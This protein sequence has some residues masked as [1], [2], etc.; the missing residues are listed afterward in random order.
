MPRKIILYIACSL[1]GYIATQ[2]DD[3]SFLQCVEKEGEDYGY[4]KFTETVDTLILGRKTYQKVIEMGYNYHP[5][6]EVYVL[7]QTKN[8]APFYNGDLLELV[9]KLKNKE[10]K[11][12]YC[13]GGSQLIKALL[14]LGQI[15]EIIVSIIPVMLGAGIRLFAERSEELNNLELLGCTP[16]ETGLVQLHYAIK[17]KQ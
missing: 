1:D 5:D 3:I 2:N 10:G 13:D 8:E 14:G 9:Q 12:I 16:F 11:N 15:D 6:K 4:T 7:S 17:N